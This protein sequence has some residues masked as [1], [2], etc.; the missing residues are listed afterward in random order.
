MQD[1]K[2]LRDRYHISYVVLQGQGERRVLLQNGSGCMQGDTVAPPL[3]S[4]TY[5]KELVTWKF[6]GDRF[7]MLAH[8]DSF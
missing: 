1:K 2:F 3:F 7:E 5:D 6:P 8:L 4:E